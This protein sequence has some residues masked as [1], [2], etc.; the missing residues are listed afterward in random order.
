MGFLDKYVYLRIDWRSGIQCGES[1]HEAIVGQ[2]RDDHDL[3][4]GSD[5][6]NPRDVHSFRNI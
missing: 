1:H 2:V 3:D 4:Q 5:G 6:G